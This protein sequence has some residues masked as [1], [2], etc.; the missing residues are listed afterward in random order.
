[1]AFF[2]SGDDRFEAMCFITCRKCSAASALY[3][4]DSIMIM[5]NLQELAHS[6]LVVRKVIF[7]IGDG[8]ACAFPRASSH[9]FS[10]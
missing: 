4:G 1:M 10:S 9:L 2:R 3:P 7:T 6:R 5:F 8:G